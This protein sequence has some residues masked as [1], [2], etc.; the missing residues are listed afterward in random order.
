LNPS[1]PIVIPDDL[2]QAI[3]SARAVTVLTGA[4]ISAE[5]GIPTFRDSQTGLWARY[6]PQELA[7]PQAFAQNPG[8]VMDWYRW[9]KQIVDKASPNAGHLA[10]AQLEKLLHNFTLITQN[11]DGLHE[12]AGS[13]NIVELH[14]SLQRLR[15]SSDT[16]AY[17]T[18]DW[19]EEGL[20]RCPECGHLLRPDVVWFGEMLSTTALETAVQAARSSDIFFSIGTSGV[21]EPAA[22]LPYEALR[23]GAVIVEINPQPTPLSLSGRYFFPY[24]AGEALPVIVRAVMDARPL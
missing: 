16:C 14:G 12:R 2:A 9:R 18:R 8:L 23:S 21:V 15:C 19:P 3:R 13:K 22:S 11:V 1:N 7:T 10:L 24:P 5:S 4:G 17:I 6:Q 20:S